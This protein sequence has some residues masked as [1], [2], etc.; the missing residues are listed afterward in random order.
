MLQQ[1]KIVRAKRSLPLNRYKSENKNDLTK[2]ESLPSAEADSDVF[3][4]QVKRV[5]KTHKSEFECIAAQ[6]LVI[7]DNS[8]QRSMDLDNRA[9]KNQYDNRSNSLTVSMNSMS[10]KRSLLPRWSIFLLATTA[11]LVYFY[12]FDLTNIYKCP[13]QTNPFIYLRKYQ[14]NFYPQRSKDLFNPMD[15]NVLFRL[16]ELMQ[17]H[18][19][20]LCNLIVTFFGEIFFCI[21]KYEYKSKIIY[22]TTSTYEYLFDYFIHF[23]Q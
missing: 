7:H 8:A 13:F 23:F 1:K 15:K 3:R 6:E 20:S 19:F 22:V 10:S 16:G 9:S 4:R 17:N 12:L 5:K 21:D 14:L 11:M 2:L 18:F